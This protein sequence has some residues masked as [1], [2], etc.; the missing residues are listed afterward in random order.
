MRLVTF[1]DSSHSCHAGALTPRG[2]IVDL[3]AAY[4]LYLREV[5]KEAGFQQKAETRVPPVMR[6]LFAGGDSSLDAARAA[7]DFV[8][9]QG[10]GVVGP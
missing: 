9:G 7:L 3:T 2:E 8:A 4:A 10:N 1:E 6:K 5:K